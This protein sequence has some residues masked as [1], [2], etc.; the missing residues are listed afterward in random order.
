M[1]LECYSGNLLERTGYEF[2]IKDFGGVRIF[3]Y[4]SSTIVCRAL[5]KFEG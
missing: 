3:K 5:L 4:Q 2:L 1:F